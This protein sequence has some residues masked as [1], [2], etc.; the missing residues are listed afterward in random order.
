MDGL[1]VLL[2]EPTPN[3]GRRGGPGLFGRRIRLRHIE[4]AE[5]GSE[6]RATLE[7]IQNH[8]RTRGGA[9]ALRQE[10]LL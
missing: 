1:G 2:N 7:S 4:L 8:V 6:E 10:S 5:G 9:S 3:G